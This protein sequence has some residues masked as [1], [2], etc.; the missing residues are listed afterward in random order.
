MK[1]SSGLV[2]RWFGTAT[3]ISTRKQAEE[4]VRESEARYRG[5]FENMIEGFAYCKMIFEYGE[6]QDFISLS[7]NHAFETLT[8]L[9][10]AVGKRVTEVIPGIR[11]ADPGLFEI[12]GRVSLTG[13]PERFEMFVEALKMWFSI[14]VYSPEKEFF[15]A[16][17][18]VIAGARK[19]KRHRAAWRQSLTAR[20]AII[21]KD[22]NGIIQT[23]NVGAENIFGYKAE[24]VIGKPVSLLIP[25][26]HTDEVPEILERIKQGE[27]IE[28]F[29]TE[30]MRKD[31]TIVPVDTDVLSHQG[32]KRQ[33]YWRIKDCTRYHCPQADRG[34]AAGERGAVSQF[35]QHD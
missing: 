10:D 15:V 34:G 5:L 13:K 33:N 9:K 2:L 24:E 16:A 8:G 20:N 21:G 23:W 19:R 28:N 29:E 26:G 25:P 17:F 4:A 27:H 14:S 3:D 30:R 11:D 18:D 22:L 6:P 32:Y 1:D 35:V 31:G 12:Y 7:V